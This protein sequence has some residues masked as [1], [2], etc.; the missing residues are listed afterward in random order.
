VLLDIP[1]KDQGASNIHEMLKIGPAQDFLN[2]MT[3]MDLALECDGFVGTFYSNWNRLIDELRS[4]VRCKAE[5]AYVDVNP[6]F[7]VENN[8]AHDIFWMWI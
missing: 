1:Y 8:K 2:A 6:D 3:A 7:S 4:T 5:A